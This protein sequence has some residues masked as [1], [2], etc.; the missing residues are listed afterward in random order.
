M[1]T[2]P[3]LDKLSQLRLSAFRAALED[4]MHSPHY[5]EL[6][7]EELL[8]LVPGPDFPTG[9]MIIGQRGIAEA[10]ATG[11]G[12]VIVRGTVSQ[13]TIGKKDTLV[14]NSIPYQVV[15]NALIEKIVDAARNGRIDGIS[16]IKNFSGKNHRTRIV[17]YL[18]RDADPDV[19]ERQL[20]HHVHGKYAAGHQF[21][22]S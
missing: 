20:Y 15:Q 14:I 16:D 8:Q 19:V 2:Q 17:I 22:Q 18:K 1:L 3:L 4:Q 21:A 12:R 5:A 11:R 7:F 13:E 9:G 10:Y 6:S